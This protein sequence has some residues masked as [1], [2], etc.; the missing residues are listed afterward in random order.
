MGVLTI[1][2]M[3]SSVDQYL[4]LIRC[5]GLIEQSRHIQDGKR[6]RRS[7]GVSLPA[8]VSQSRVRDIEIPILINTIH[9]RGCCDIEC[10]STDR[11]Q[12]LKR[13]QSRDQRELAIWYT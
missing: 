13:E 4:G 12:I 11:G 7:P 2:M 6:S 8:N 3:H 5:A 10:I 1:P 9:V